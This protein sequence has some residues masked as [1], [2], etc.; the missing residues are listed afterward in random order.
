MNRRVLLNDLLALW[1]AN[2]ELDQNLT[3]DDLL[4]D[5]ATLGM[6]EASDIY[7][8]RMIDPGV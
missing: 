1:R 2:R 4:D 6:K 7:L 3:I 8:S 5:L